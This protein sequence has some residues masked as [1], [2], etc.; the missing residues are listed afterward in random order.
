MNTEELAERLLSSSLGTL[1]VC[2]VYLGEQ[3][4][5]YDALSTKG[6]LTSTELAAICS[7]HPRYVTEWLEQQCVS[8]LIEV[9]A[10]QLPAGERRYSLPAGHA[11]VLTD[12]DSLSYLAPLARLLVAAAG[13][14]PA[15]LEAYRTGGGVPWSAYGD[16]MRTGQA[17]M[18]RPWFLTALGTQWFP[19]AADLHSRLQQGGRVAD[20]GCGE[21]WSSIGMVKSYPGTVV[22]GYDIDEASVIAARQHAEKAGVADRVRFHHVDAATV[23]RD[24]TYDVVT[25]FECIHDMGDP[26]NVLATMRRLAKPDGQVV[27]MDEAVPEGFSGAGDEVER[28]M[29]GLSL[30]ICLPDGMSHPGSVGTGTVMRPDTLRHYAQQAGFA[31]I[32]VLP[33]END[34]W[35]FYRLVPPT[36]SAA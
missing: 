12:R 17:D 13:Q 18:N 8:G 2:S 36:G 4:G 9:E 22:D 29:Y 26:V 31:D 24:A 14:L 7:V 33:I 34:L 25:A 19:A 20:V 3:L 27:V 21:G 32:E 35:R 11:E 28:L 1:E 30:M 6:P 15:L 10:P 16:D 23:G 5:L